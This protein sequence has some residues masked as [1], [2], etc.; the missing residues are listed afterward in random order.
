MKK[1]FIL[2]TI[3]AI[4]VSLKA[5]NLPTADFKPFHFGFALGVNTLNY[6]VEPTLLPV[7]GQTYQADIDVLVPGF[8]VGVIGDL[9]LN[10]YLN[11]RLVPSLHLGQRDLKYVNDQ[12]D[13]IETQT[14]KSNIFTVPLYLKYSAVR[15]D[16][17]RP[18][19]MAGGGLA[20]DFGREREKPVLLKDIDYFVDFGVGCTFYFEYFRFSPEIKLA[21][22][23]N[24]IFASLPDRKDDYI[25]PEDQH[26]S[27]ALKGLMSRLVTLTFNFE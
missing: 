11:I 22:G 6:L 17:Y 14:V 18:Y 3:V 20:L 23:L 26:Y 24:N 19:L 9:R 2:L 12:N 13:E 7:G 25:A 4:S 15:I 8:S 10:D 27:Q 5:Q 21:L 16:N 1:L